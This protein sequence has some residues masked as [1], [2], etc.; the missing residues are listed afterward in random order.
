MA[1]MS[2]TINFGAVEMPKSVAF[3]KP[4]FYKLSATGAKYIKPEGKKAD[5]SAKSPYVEISFSGKDGELKDKFYVTTGSFP[6]LKYLHKMWIDKDLDKEF[7]S[8]DAVGAY[9]EKLFNSDQIKKI[10][11]TMVIGGEE[12]TNG[13]IYAHIAPFDFIIPD[14]IDME[15]G[16]WDENGANYRQ[17]V[18]LQQKVAVNNNSMMLPDS[19]VPDTASSTPKFSDDMPF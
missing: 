10:S 11:H 3:L 18:K 13:K 4:G 17:H 12:G 8:I 2:N 9:F 6:R 19:A 7:A 14:S 1:D 5:G 15:T 16:A